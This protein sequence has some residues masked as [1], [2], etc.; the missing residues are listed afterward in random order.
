[1]GVK[2]L[3][4]KKPAIIWE[5]TDYGKSLR[6]LAADSLEKVNIKLLS[7][8]SYVPQ[9]DRDYSSHVTKL[10]AKG[11]DGVFFMGEYTATALFLKQAKNMAL[12][13]K[14]VCSSGAANTQLI[15][16]A[17][18]SAEGTY[19]ITMFDPNDARPLPAAFI[20]NYQKKYGEEP[21][22]W[23]AHSYDIVKLVKAAMEKG[24]HDRKSLIEELH[25]LPEFQGVTGMIK[26]DQYGDV[27]GKKAA[28]LLVKDGKFN[29][30]L[31]TKY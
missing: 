13:L 6:D 27:P 9:V 7:D 29:G 21:G 1:M 22:D 12:D 26:F 8:D 28:V 20:A 23:G 4:I 11:V 18:E 19:V 14:V 5:N 15:N 16:I 10:K 24:A 25:K 2:E 3:N 30:Y 31:P 17:G